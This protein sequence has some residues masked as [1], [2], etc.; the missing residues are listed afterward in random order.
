MIVDAHL[1][2]FKRLTGYPRELFWT[3]L[4][5]GRAAIHDVSTMRKTEGAT[6]RRE[7]LRADLLELLKGAEAL[8]ERLPPYRW[9]ATQPHAEV[10]QR[11]PPCEGTTA[12][13]AE[14]ALAYMDWVGVDKAFLMQ[15]PAYGR[16]NRYFAEVVYQWPDRFI[17]FADVDWRKGK[18]AAED[19][20]RWIVYEGLRGC[21]VEVGCTKAAYPEFSVLGENEMRVWEMCEK[22]GIPIF[23]HLEPGKEPCEEIRTL[24]AEF[25]KLTLIVG[26]LGMPNYN[27]AWRDQCLLA[28]HERVYLEI[29]GLPYFF[30][31][32][33][34]PYPSGQECIKWAVSEIGAEKMLWGSDAP[35]LL[36]WCTYEQTLNLVRT[37]C[38]FLNDEQ[39]SLILGGT[40][41]RL[42]EALPI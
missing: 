38:D 18:K 1:H 14:V 32:E 4:D 7:T 20:E 16:Q 22:L 39:R 15:G 10:I 27:A 6:E 37:K 9:D 19:L 17:G 25:P 11:I 41:E 26:H 42:I 13:P 3:A 23:F 24:L 34:Y 5:L 28:K 33:E 31:E 12:F 35:V 29:S 21:K 36:M 30:R 40:A 2:I 8:G